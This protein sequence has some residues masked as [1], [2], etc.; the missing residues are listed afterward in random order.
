MTHAASGQRILVLGAGYSGLMAA[1]GTARRTRRQGGRVRLVNPATRFT[2]RLRLRLRQTA[3][4]QELADLQI[5]QMLQGTGIEFVQGWVT[6]ID[7][8]VREVRIDGERVLSYDTLV[9]ALGSVADTASVPGGTDHVY[10]LNSPQEAGRLA[11]RLAELE[12]DGGT[13]VIG[14]GGLTGVESA[15]E[16]AESHPGVRVVLLCRDVPGA[17]MGAKARAYLHAALQRLGVEVRAGVDIAEVLPDAIELADG[18][19]VHAD[20]CLWTAGVRV[21]TLAAEAGLTVDGRGRIVVDATLR[22]VSHPQVYA[23]GD[24]AAIRQSYGVVHGTCQ[25]GIPT[26]A[27][28][29][30][31]IARQIR[32]K[33]PTPFR[34]VTSTSRSAWAAATR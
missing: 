30:I 29:A 7:A 9:Y 15:A 19:M 16:I 10:T 22:S 6:G 24:A 3:A 23:I 17:M 13:V 26:A 18:E 8:Q 12:P 20:A 1:I 31:S 32:G 28:A 34:L 27:H 5:P 21:S 14:G 2:E 33:E 11:Q 4:G 25:S